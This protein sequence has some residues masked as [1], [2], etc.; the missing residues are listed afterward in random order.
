MVIASNTIAFNT[1][2]NF[3]LMAWRWTNYLCR[4]MSLLWSI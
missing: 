3:M 2:M 4:N 1:F